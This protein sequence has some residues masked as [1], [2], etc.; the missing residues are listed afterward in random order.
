MKIAIFENEYES[1]KGAFETANLLRFN[2]KL[3]FSVFTSSQNADFL[4]IHNY[5]IIF[6]DIDL[7]SKSFLDGFGVINKIKE[8]DDN[9]MK[10]TIILTGNNK[11]K[12]AMDDR[13]ISD[14]RINII[15]KPT[16]YEE[17]SSII[18]KIV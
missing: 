8:I 4:N 1:I 10:R 18:K 6:I 11:I 17:I 7:S 13:N 5:S 3:E 16:N 15:I 14:P 12:E 2:K 9:L